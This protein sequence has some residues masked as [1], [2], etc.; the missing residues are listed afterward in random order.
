M[1]AVPSRHKYWL[2]L[3]AAAACWGVATVI[4][5]RAVDEI[6]PLTLL[7][8][9]LLVSVGV[10][11]VLVRGQGLE[12]TWSPQLRR[13]GAL[14]ILNPGASYALSLLGLAYISASL[15]MLLWAV[16]PLMI[17]AIAWW[18]LRDRVTV[19]L[20]GASA[21]ALAGV[22]LVILAPGSR[23]RLP[24]IAL[25]L[26]GVAACAVY[27]VISRKW[28][29]NDST[30]AIVAVQQSCALVFSL[31]LLAATTLINRTAIIPEASVGA[32]ISAA[33]AGVLYYAV[34]FWFYLTGLRR[35]SAAFAGIF[36]NL[37]PVF[38]IAAGHLLLAERLTDR[39]WLGALLIVAAVG[40]M[41]R[42]QSLS[43]T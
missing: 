16:E 42:Q 40:S 3:T 38:G 35:V 5:K 2:S 25:T 34:A 23:G 20:A 10:L 41:A 33:V 18:L 12:V 13:L 30:L 17:L 28:M 7:P 9:Q 29:D 14:G 8:L 6:P 39:Q 32:W 24:G 37:I 19:P 22:L 15:S 1:L 27:T 36:I 4:S 21:L 26:A 43:S 31:L 11:A